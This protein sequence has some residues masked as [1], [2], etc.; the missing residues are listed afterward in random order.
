MNHSSTTIAPESRRVWIIAEGQCGKVDLQRLGKIAPVGPVR[1]YD[2]SQIGRYMINPGPVEA[3]KRL[4]GCQ[5]HPIAGR[6]LSKARLRRWLSGSLRSEPP[7]PRTVMARAHPMLPPLE[8]EALAQHMQ[9]LAD[10]VSGFDPAIGLLRDTDIRQVG[11]VVGICEDAGGQRSFLTIQGSIAEKLDYVIEHL[12]REVVVILDRAYGRDGFF[13]LIGMDLSHFDPARRFSLLRFQHEGR[14]KAC[15]LDPEGRL[16][17][18]IEDPA[19][20]QYLLLFEQSIQSNPNLLSS[21]E[22]CAGGKALP[23]KLYF[24]KQLNIVYSGANPPA[25]F[26]DIFQKMDAAPRLREKVLEMLKERQVGVSFNYA[27]CD[28]AGDQRLLTEVSVL[29]DCRVLDAVRA[30]LPDL[31]SEIGQRASGS[32]IGRFYLLDAMRGSRHE[33]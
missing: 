2:L 31:A 1:A 18:W 12:N 15:V 26:K 5:I 22:L 32:E 8:T 16:D 3:T 21:L 30:H 6:R 4:V 24:K 29:Q 28:P 17:F 10:R 33:Q 20:V 14:V 19:L 7:T 23:L 13:D 11:D 27:P 25:F 9:R